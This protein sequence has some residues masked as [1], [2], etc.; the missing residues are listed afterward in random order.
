ME[1]NAILGP[2]AVLALWSMV[3]WVWMYA[4]R[5]PAMSRA[6]ID[7]AKMVGGTGK[8]LDDVLPQEVQWKAHNYNHLMEQPTVFYAVAL[9]LAIGGMGGGI[10]AQIAWAYVAL[11]IVHSL[12]QVTV[13]RV[14][15]RFGVFALA[16]LALLA[17]CLHAF[18]GFVLH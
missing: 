8:G 11:R 18:I 5:I 3:M 1:N 2:V 6:K 15:W 12:I 13:N 17:L 7:A 10:N 14:L 9:A 4:T 16:S